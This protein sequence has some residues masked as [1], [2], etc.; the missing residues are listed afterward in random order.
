MDKVYI[1]RWQ[2]DLINTNENVLT[3]CDKPYQTNNWIQ[4]KWEDI[5]NLRNYALGLKETHTN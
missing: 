1:V 4:Q 5:V 3:I 2:S